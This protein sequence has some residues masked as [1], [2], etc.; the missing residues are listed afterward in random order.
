MRKSRNI[1]RSFSMID[2]GL[3]RC[4]LHK[5]VSYVQLNS[6]Y[7][8]ASVSSFPAYHAIFLSTDFCSAFSLQRRLIGVLRVLSE[9][10]ILS[11]KSASV[12][13]RQDFKSLFSS[14]IHNYFHFLIFTYSFASLTN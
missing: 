13:H 12:L 10:Q 11:S 8:E 1:L 9:L 4:H 3:R 2:F 7:T 6:F 5:V 14:S